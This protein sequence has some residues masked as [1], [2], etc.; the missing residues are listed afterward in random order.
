MIDDFRS[1]INIILGE[2]DRRKLEGHEITLGVQSFFIHPGY[3][4]ES[5]HNDIA[6]IKT[7][8]KVA[9]NDY[10]KPICLP[11]DK[12]TLN[13]GDEVEIAG[14]GQTGTCMYTNLLHSYY[15]YYYCHYYYSCSCSCSS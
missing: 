5:L 7:S 8:Q 10:V 6:L 11:D 13:I 4:P 1:T 9:F 3:D 14:W 2:L 15:Y 12:L